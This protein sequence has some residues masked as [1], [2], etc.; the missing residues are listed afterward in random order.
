MYVC[1]TGRNDEDVEAGITG[2]RKICIPCRIILK[3]AAAQMDAAFRYMP[4]GRGVDSSHSHRNF[5]LT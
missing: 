1:L 3:H 4:Q 2:I 5:S